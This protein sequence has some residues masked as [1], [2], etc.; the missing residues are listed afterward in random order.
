MQ[1]KTLD[2]LI[3]TINRIQ[4]ET[5]DYC[6]YYIPQRNFDFAFSD[7]LFNVATSRSKS[8]TLI[9]TDIPI[10]LINIRSNKVYEFISKCER[11]N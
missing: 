9:I 5:V 4:G 8:T 3:E 2:I 6:I 7:N 1:S 10:D 11:I